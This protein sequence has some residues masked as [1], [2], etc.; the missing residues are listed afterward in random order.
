MGGVCGRSVWE[1]CVRGGVCEGRSMW[2]E[3]VRGGVCGRSVWEEC[4]GGD[5]E[6]EREGG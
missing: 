1:E 4:E 5:G 3:C 2:E 6:W